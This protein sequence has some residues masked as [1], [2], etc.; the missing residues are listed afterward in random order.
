MIFSV[1]ASLLMFPQPGNKKART[2]FWQKIPEKGLMILRRENLQP[3]YYLSFKP[4]KG[5]QMIEAISDSTP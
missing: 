2:M 3:L 5:F 1:V 4:S